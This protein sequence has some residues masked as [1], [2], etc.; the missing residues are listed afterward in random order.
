MVQASQ[1]R[2]QMPV[3]PSGLWR[4]RSTSRRM[5]RMRVDAAEIQWATLAPALCCEAELLGQL[6]DADMGMFPQQKQTLSTT[7][8][9]TD[10]ERHRR[11]GV[12]IVR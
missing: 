10:V 5:M 6:L 2:L 7:S 9:R 4:A 3:P 1:L 8:L 11:S 12:W